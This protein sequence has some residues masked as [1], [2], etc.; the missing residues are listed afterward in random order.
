VEFGVVAITRASNHVGTL[1]W[2][3][4]IPLN[5]LKKDIPIVNEFIL[6]TTRV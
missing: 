6:G 1:L 4:K 3:V 5:G 2:R